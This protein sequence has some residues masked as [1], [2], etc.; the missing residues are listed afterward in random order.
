[1][2]R[3][4]KRNIKAD[5]RNYMEALTTEAAHQKNMWDLYSIIKKLLG[6]FS[7]PGRP[8][9]DKKERKISNEEGQK[10]RWMKHFGELQNRPAPHDPPDIQPADRDP[11]MDCGVPTKEAASNSE[12]SNSTWPGSIPAEA[13]TA[14]INTSVKMLDS[15][16]KQ[17]V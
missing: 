11:Q 13:M 17:I 7:K 3:S 1:M 4:V 5:N 14:Y 9:K 12:A 8:T 2:N 16:I 6:K 10:D 15:L